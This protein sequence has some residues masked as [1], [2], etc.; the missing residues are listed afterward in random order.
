[1]SQEERA[2]NDFAK[3]KSTRRAN[4]GV[5]TKYDNEIREIVASFTDPQK[6]RE[7]FVRLNSTAITLKEKRQCLNALDDAILA[8]TDLGDVENEIDESSDWETRIYQWSEKIEVFKRGDFPAFQ[9]L[10]QVEQQSPGPSI[11]Q[12][13]AVGLGANGDLLGA[14]DGVVNS[15]QIFDGNLSLGGGN[16]TSF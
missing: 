12:A 14:G 6:A 3:L 13:T 2:V 4:R 15:S 8:K 11:V 16:S 7:K 9:T 5:V 1:M 10:S